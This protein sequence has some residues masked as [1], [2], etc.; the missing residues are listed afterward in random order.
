MDKRIRNKLV[1]QI[2]RLC[3]KQYRKGFQHGYF[4]CNENILTE[5]EVD[6]F[7]RKGAREGYSKV[8]EPLHSNFK[9]DPV[10]RIRAEISMKGM[11][12][13]RWFLDEFLS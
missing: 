1:K 8:E 4:A 9:Y 6:E 7:R 12:E 5:K 2:C 11:D 3:E 13:L 10:R